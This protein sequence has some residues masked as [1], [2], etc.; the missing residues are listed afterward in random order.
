MVEAVRFKVEPAQIGPLLPA[1][2]AEGQ[3]DWHTPA[4][5]AL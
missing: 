3:V 5:P 4:V 2:G 1:A